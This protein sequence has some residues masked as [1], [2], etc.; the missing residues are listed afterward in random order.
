[1][2]ALSVRNM[3]YGL[4]AFITSLTPQLQAALT[5][6]IS[7]ENVYS[8]E[9]E[10]LITKKDDVYLSC[11]NTLNLVSSRIVHSYP[12]LHGFRKIIVFL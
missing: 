7:K 6:T 11:S 2:G 12:T 4:Q 9:S 3:K 1:M 10:F 8:W 5:V